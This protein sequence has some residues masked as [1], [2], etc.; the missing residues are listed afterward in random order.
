MPCYHPLKAYRRTDCNT[1]S[2]NKNGQ[3]TNIAAPLSLPCGQCTGCRL[4][5]SKQWAIRCV[6]EA[7]LYENNCFITLT[8]N[9]ENLPKDFSL[10]KRDFQ[11]FM[12]RLRK[13]YVPTNPYD[14]KTQEALYDQFHKKHEIRFYH[15]GEYGEPTEFNNYV[16]RPHYH[17]II[18]N[19]KFK[20]QTLWKTKRGTE[21]FTS[22]ELEELWPKGFSTIGTVTYDSAGYVARYLLKKLN[23]SDKS[24]PGVKE[25]H[26]KQY[27]HVDRKTGEA[28]PLL[29]EY[30]TM[31]RKPGIA[32]AWF[33]KWG[34]D[35][36]PNDSVVMQGKER[37]V[38]KFY[39]TIY[40]NNEPEKFD[41][42]K[43]KR[44]KNMQKHA[45][46]NTPDRLASKEIVKTAQIGKLYREYEE[47]N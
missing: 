17:A 2:F 28:F 4:E 14:K 44:V 13:K 6:H 27:T 24:S 16:A 36:F 12:K 34:K 20:D 10:N 26:Q 31:S 47:S 39:D 21:L 29:P 25:R 11:L 3:Y 19:H 7:S 5:R 45:K 46:D 23:L 15:C 9:N 42:I 22:A 8:Y 37:T 43:Q 1:L 38:P 33:E 18:F 35:V 30:T 32:R 41:I 40:Q